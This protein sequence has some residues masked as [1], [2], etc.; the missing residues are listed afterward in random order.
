MTPVARQV[1]ASRIHVLNRG[2]VDPGGRFVLYW[3]IASR[4]CAWS[5]PLQ[6]AVEWARELG[7]PLLV[8][9]ALR[10][11]YPWAGDRIHRFVLDGMADNARAC[12]RAG[13]RYHAYVEPRRGAGKGLL[14]ALARR[15]SVVVTDEFPAFFLPRMTAVAAKR[16]PVRLEAV[17]GN[18]LQPLRAT[19]GRVFTRARDFRRFL[20]R[21]LPDHL[22]SFPA[23]APLRRL[24]TSR[25][26]VVPREILRRWPPAPGP[27]LEGDGIGS[28]PIGHD[29]PPISRRGG[30]REA[31]KNLRRFLGKHLKGYAEGRRDLVPPR[32]SGLSPYLHFGHVSAHQVFHRV[33]EGENWSPE[34]V[35]TTPDG[36]REGWWG[37]KAG[38]EAFLEQLVTW[39]ELGFNA[40]FGDPA[41]DRYASLPGWARRTLE[42]HAGDERPYLY[43]PRELEEARTHDRLWNAAQRQLLTEGV[44]HNALRMLWGKKILEW[45]PGPREA[46]E[47][48]FELNNRWA[49]DGRDPNSASGILWVLGKFDRAWG[50]ERPVFG[51]VRYM[52]SESAERKLRVAPYLERY[53]AGE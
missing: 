14:E 37:M 32:T 13:V 45:S 1:P 16:I 22:Q 33:A 52:S 23:R 8:L 50:P 27:L 12:S 3:M 2:D 26:A 44:I 29:V 51:T 47:V 34:C 5:F 18:G 30:P 39:R 6:R 9:E 35:G 38:A 43:S 28:L 10:C 36:R 19:Q 49:I 41:Y 20:Q 15:S 24:D 46:L 21:S 17:D 42:E 40:A 7:K 53:G 48:L 4:R 31:E 11:D 25:R